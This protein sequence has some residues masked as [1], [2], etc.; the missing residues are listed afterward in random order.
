MAAHAGVAAAEL[1]S[2]LGGGGEEVP[3]PELVPPG[4]G[5]EVRI[6]EGH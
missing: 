3:R 6:W 5:A 2:F 4:G 1:P